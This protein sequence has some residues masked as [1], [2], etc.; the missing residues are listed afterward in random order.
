MANLLFMVL[1]LIGSLKR[2]PTHAA[3]SKAQGL[4]HGSGLVGCEYECEY[5]N[6]F[7]DTEQGGCSYMTS[8]I[9]DDISGVDG[10]GA[11]ILA[12]DALLTF[13]QWWRMYH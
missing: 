9:F 12:T 6:W 10:N 4:N 3:S 13:S 8:P 7:L 1:L 2:Q 11:N 5:W